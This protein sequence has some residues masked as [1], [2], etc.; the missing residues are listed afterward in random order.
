M[1]IH[2]SNYYVMYLLDQ[3]FVDS[4]MLVVYNSCIISSLSVTLVTE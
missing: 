3:T 1:D 2:S 4:V